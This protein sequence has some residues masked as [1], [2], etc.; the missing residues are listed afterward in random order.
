VVEKISGTP[1]PQFGEGQMGAGWEPEKDDDTEAGR[2]ILSWPEGKCAEARAILAKRWGHTKVDALAI[3]QT[4]RNSVRGTEHEAEA[5]TLVK[6][7]QAGNDPDE[8]LIDWEDFVKSKD[9]KGWERLSPQ[10]ED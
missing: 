3:V 5:V 1:E 7:L 2:G 9:E 10:E 6:R 8:V 4:W